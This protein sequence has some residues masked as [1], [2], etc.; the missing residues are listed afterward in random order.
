MVLKVGD[1]CGLGTKLHDVILVFYKD[2]SG[3]GV[4]ILS[5]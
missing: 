3:F 5:K 1:K 4:F 2:E